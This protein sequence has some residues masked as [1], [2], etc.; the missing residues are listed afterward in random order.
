MLLLVLQADIAVSRTATAK[1][2]SEQA[3][4]V[5]VQAREDADT[6]RICAKQ[7][8]PEFKQPG[9][10]AMRAMQQNRVQ[11]VTANHV[12]FESPP[13][14][15]SQDSRDFS[16]DEMLLFGSPPLPPNLASSSFGQSP[17]PASS[18]SAANYQPTS[19]PTQATNHPGYQ[20]GG[21][22]PHQSAAPLGPPYQALSNPL[23]SSSFLSNAVPH[24]ITVQHQQPQIPRHLF[25][26]HYQATPGGNYS[27]SMNYTPP[28][29]ST[30]PQEQSFSCD[31][32]EQAQQSSNWSQVD[33][34]SPSQQA[35]S[36]EISRN[37][38]KV[39]TIL[40]SVNLF[41]YSTLDCLKVT[42]K[43]IRLVEDCSL[44]KQI[45][46]YNSTVHALFLPNMQ[47]F[48]CDRQ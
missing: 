42:I 47:V 39:T 27:S 10:E 4:Y 41:S 18:F 36:R 45:R 35:T 13:S 40:Y 1:E 33:Q 15:G 29:Y 46:D 32:S 16:S 22:T 9:A 7:F 28:S 17:N 11:N 37:P 38:S 25:Q 6:A 44:M 26:T 31:P 12:S 2:R 48:V 21:S 23:P 14:K 24:S 30:H 20:A 8:A 5:A 3:E 34:S 43:R 19:T